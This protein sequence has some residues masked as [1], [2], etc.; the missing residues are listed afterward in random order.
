VD[1]WWC[2]QDLDSSF[3][4]CLHDGQERDAAIA[5]WARDSPQRP[6]RGKMER[7][8]TRWQEM[9]GKRRKKEKNLSFSPLSG[10]GRTCGRAQRS[11]RPRP[12]L[13]D[14]VRVKGRRAVRVRCASVLFFVS[15][16]LLTRGERGVASCAAGA[17][18]RARPGP[19]GRSKKEH[20]PPPSATT[21]TTRTTPFSS[22]SYLASGP[23]PGAACPP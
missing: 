18:D 10:G 23:A 12:C 9:D 7:E 2:V 8:K 3:C 15:L 6:I 21:A 19:V 13:C 1:G 20:I 11:A 5:L 17:S 16:K 22:S 4:F 14:C